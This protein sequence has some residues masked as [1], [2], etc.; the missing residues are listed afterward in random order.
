MGWV[1][2]LPFQE[3]MWKLFIVNDYFE[4]CDWIAEEAVV[5]K[6]DKVFFNFEKIGYSKGN[7]KIWS[8][9]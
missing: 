2:N 1:S 6:V 9:L 8:A 7:S 5:G 4:K 3:T